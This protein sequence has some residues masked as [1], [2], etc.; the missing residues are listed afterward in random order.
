MYGHSHSAPWP[1]HWYMVPWINHD[2]YTWLLANTM[3]LT[4]I[5]GHLQTLW[6]W[7]VYM[8]TPIHHHLDCIHGYLQTAWPW[9]E[10]MVTSL[11]HDWPWPIY[12]NTPILYTWLLTN[13]MT[14]T[15][16]HAYSHTTS[17]P[18][19]VLTQP[20]SHHSSMKQ[21][22]PEPTFTAWFTLPVASLCVASLT[23]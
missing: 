20:F 8:I 6:P 21:Y 19:P 18:W 22:K 9:T 13:I 16:I 1:C 17:W 10:H 4:Y 2:L 3:T 7:P 15:Y 12:M 14:L 23:H 11:H 5:H